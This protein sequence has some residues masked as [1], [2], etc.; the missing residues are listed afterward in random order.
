MIGQLRDQRVLQT[1]RHVRRR[2]RG[3]GV[4]HA[5][6]DPTDSL[7]GTRHGFLFAALDEAWLAC[8][9]RHRQGD[10]FA[11]GVNRARD[12]QAR[13][14]WKRQRIELQDRRA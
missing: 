7:T 6:F 12:R 4:A 5:C 14:V 11:A 2:D 10:A 13:T 8:G 9:R 1:A 3:H